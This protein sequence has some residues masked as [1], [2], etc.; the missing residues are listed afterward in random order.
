M[1]LKKQICKLTPKES[2]AMAGVHPGEC[3][4]AKKQGK[5]TCKKKGARK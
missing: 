3:K 4:C 5:T 1:R 2:G